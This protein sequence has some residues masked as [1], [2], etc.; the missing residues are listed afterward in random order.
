[1]LG[2]W[3]GPWL[4]QVHLRCRCTPNKW[5]VE[6][7]SRSNGWNVWV[8]QQNGGSLALSKRR[9]GFSGGLCSCFHD[10]MDGVSVD[11]TQERERER[12]RASL[13]AFQLLML[14]LFLF[15][16]LPSLIFSPS[17]CE[18]SLTQTVTFY[19]PSPYIRPTFAICFDLKKASNLSCVIATACIKITKKK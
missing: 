17:A 16:I 12:K 10:V 18:A 15:F 3:V 8:W 7:Q 14:T 1:M 6:K 9:A 2:V 5:Q 19:K 4:S 13:S 11:Y